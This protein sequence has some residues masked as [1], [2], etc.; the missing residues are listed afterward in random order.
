MSKL[1]EN[2]SKAWLWL[3]LIAL[4]IGGGVWVIWRNFPR[5]ER[6]AA[7]SSLDSRFETS[8]RA[9]SFLENIQYG[10][11][12]A[13]YAELLKQFPDDPAYLRN[14][15]I[16]ALA[17]VKYH[18]DLSQDPK[19]DVE[20]IRSMLPDLFDK[21]A[22]A[23]E[24][25]RQSRPDDPI[26]YQLDALR[27]ARW[28]AILSAANPIIA[29]EEQAKLLEKLKSYVERFP[30]NAFLVTQFNNSAEVMSSVDPKILEETVA[31][32][33]RVREANPRNIYLLCLLIQR[34]VQLKDPSVLELVEPL[35]S[36]LE[37][38]EWKWKME[39]RPK[40]LSDLR[41][42]KALGETDVEAAMGVLIGWVGEAKST[43][44]SLVDAKSIEIS[45]LAFLDLS[46]VQR[47]LQ[48]RSV[49]ERTMEIPKFQ[50]KRLEVADAVGVKFFDWNVDTRAEL[51][52]WTDRALKLGEVDSTRG[53][54]ELSE[55]PLPFAISGLM[56]VDL[57][58][59]DAHR[60]TSARSDAT[61]V[62]EAPDGAAR[63]AQ[64]ASAM[65]HETLRDVLVYGREGVAIVAFQPPVE[66]SPHWSLLSED[67]GLGDLRNV[68]AATA[69]DWESDGDLDLVFVSD[70]KLE[71]RENMGNRQFRNVNSVSM[72]PPAGTQVL[73][74]VVV[75]FDRDVDL[76]VLVSHAGGFGVLENIQ[77]G[78][79]R[80]KALDDSW[81]SLGAAGSLT[82]GD[83]NNN[84]SW[85]V[86][87]G[88]QAIEG[89]SPSTVTGAGVQL[90]STTTQLGKGVAAPLTLSLWERAAYVA[91]VD[92]NNDAQLDIVSA[93]DD[94]V[95]VWLN[96]PGLMFPSVQLIGEAVT[97]DAS[98]IDGSESRGPKRY[99]QNL[100]VA[101]LGNDGWLDV[102]ALVGGQVTLVSTQPLPDHHHLAYR[103]KGI[104]DANGGGRNNQYA[105]GA[106]VEIFGPFGYQA[107]VI[108]ED[109]VHFG[110]GAD[111]AY[112]LRTI[113]VNG[114]TQGII[115]PK[116]DSMLEEKQVLI[117]SCPFAYGWD[118]TSWQLITDLLWNAP[119][120]LQISKG[121][122]LP[123]RRWEYLMLPRKSMQPYENGY[124]LRITEELWESAYFDHVALMAI[125][126]PAELEVLSNEK[127]GPPSIAEPKLWAYLETIA[128]QSV[129]DGKER[130][131][132]E[133]CSSEDGVYAI[134]FDRHW[135][136]G[137]VETS[138]LEIDFGTID[139]QRPSQLILTGWIY[140]TDTS[141]NI[142]IGQNTDLA[143][144]AP[145]SLA[146]I[147]K[148]GQ[149]ET[150]VPFMGFP[151][152]K[153][154]TIVIPLDGLFPT[155]DHRIR[156]SHS[157]RIYWDRVRLGY[158]ESIAYA[159]SH[160]GPASGPMSRPQQAVEH[161]SLRGTW[162]PMQ[163]GQLRYRG[164]SRELPRSMHQPHWYDYHVV[165]E[166]PAWPTLGG[167]FTRWGDVL[168]ML[169]ADDDWLVVMGAGDEM[170][171]RFEIPE[172]PVPEGWVRD[173]VLHSVG[174][175]KDAA[176][177]T[178]EGQSSLPLPFS[179]MS[180]YPPG[181]E[182]REEARRIE[183][184]HRS[185]LTRKQSLE[186]FWKPTLEAGA[187]Q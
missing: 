106:T 62:Q 187:R 52:V 64:I 153:P 95:T 59:V 44:G 152:G 85:D 126:H 66:T 37:P 150:V 57:F 78:Q 13:L 35:A 38:F 167:A 114:L 103:I 47:M 171:V 183:H 107:R 19:N 12:E 157:S 87:A 148:S 9:A 151:G 112:S 48:T 178:L 121:K 94:G 88:K 181:A 123:D 27:D 186:R 29:D 86:V 156:I 127:V 166:Q 79:F 163:S 118:G 109:S 102:V 140:P 124:E 182:D 145:P 33:R 111:R 46:D 179:R 144:P 15:A 67:V 60:G 20:S 72:L 75:D 14:A 91:A 23:I 131:W 113:F 73:A 25:Y 24:R 120:G 159:G 7:E 172:E 65:R 43:E 170:Q 81:A 11:A 5:E 165:S 97:G 69:I 130:D 136:Q 98:R 34:L 154:K 10:Q 68:T 89:A 8:V 53:W 177:N 99:W 82:I 101:D 45:E 146:T 137:L 116:S 162:L 175:D 141:L 21:S 54:N 160:S 39:R 129:R 138:T 135:K 41:R 147:G 185:T 32:L 90:V 100:S 180:Q 105:V 149:F 71:L 117:G 22:A 56:T 49:E 139:L 125:D 168:D 169:R 2:R 92:W 28:I 50:S 133:A 80:Y 164:F 42:A 17:N 16:A 26:A 31:P 55:L 3:F 93:S 18:I 36:L 158:G 184:L 6:L 174:W 176:L 63:E 122:V 58:A 83:F 155:D 119:L 4:L 84:Y 40:D 128:P 96:S 108:E 142:G 61:S 51:L 110:L 173:F 76:D 30:S 70:G 134:P 74:T 161:A 143:P 132:T 104:S 1:S 77:H 115:D